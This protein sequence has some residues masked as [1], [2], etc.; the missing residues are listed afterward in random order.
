MR[1]VVLAVIVLVLSLGWAGP[2][3]A[4][5]RHHGGNRHGGGGHH[6]SYGG[7]YSGHHGG[8][9]RSHSYYG[10]GRHDDYY[11]YYG[12]LLVPHVLSALTG[13]HAS[14]RAAAP[15]P[16][17]YVEQESGY[18]YYCTDPEGYH[19]Y[20]EECPGGWMQVVPSSPPR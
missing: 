16:A 12:A 14:R 2:A 6:R 9:H 19:P 20:V 18:W 15:A 7:H 10:H 8:H 17:A 5:S 3:E 4:G 1:R 11:Y 13:W